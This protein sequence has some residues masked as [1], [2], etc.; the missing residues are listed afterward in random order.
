MP[1][2]LGFN[3]PQQSADDPQDFRF[4]EAGGRINLQSSTEIEYAIYTSNV[5]EVN[6]VNVGLEPAGSSS[7]L[8]VSTDNLI[9]PNGDDAGTPPASATRYYA[10]VCN[11]ADGLGVRFRLSLEPPAYVKGIYYLGTSGNAV[12]WRYVGTVALLGGS[13]AF[14]DDDT[15]RLI[16][17]YYNRLRKRLFTCPGY[18]DDNADTILTLASGTVWAAL[19]G[20]TGDNVAFLSNGEDSVELAGNVQVALAAGSTWRVAIGVDTSLATAQAGARCAAA[21]RN[22]QTQQPSNITLQQTFN[23]AL[24]WASLNAYT[25]STTPTVIADFARNGE[26]VDPVGTVLVGSVWV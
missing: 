20:G 2:L 16:A 8:C 1:Q 21:C 7:L 4:G 26:S 6:G 22:N 23:E 12:N 11:G 19:N 24:Y 10:Y 5:L 14:R 9:D 13:P 15:A 18:T 17:N 25:N 3:N